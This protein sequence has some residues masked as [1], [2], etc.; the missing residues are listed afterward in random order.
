[1]HNLDYELRRSKRKTVSVEITRDLRI[2]VRAPSRMKLA[3]IE[4]F[5][6]SKRGWIETHYNK[7]LLTCKQDV[8]KLTESEIASLKREARALILPKL[9]R[10]AER[11]GV[12]YSR[13]AVRLQKTRFGSCS[14]KGNLNFNALV[15]LMPEDIVDYVIVHELAHLKQMNH[16]AAFWREVE[17][18]IPD[19]RAK[20]EWLKEN[21]ANF[22]QR[23]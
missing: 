2:I 11:M 23:I 19:Y 6:E 4:A 18:V 10:Y 13:V 16:S 17:S 22:I 3:D 9:E 7:L 1:M 8:Q 12:S 21:G 14:G 5:L 15:A 20:R